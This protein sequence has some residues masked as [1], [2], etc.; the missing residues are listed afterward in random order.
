[1]ITVI[2][3]ERIRRAY[4]MDGKSMRQIEQEM[5]HSYHT[6]RKALDSAEQPPYTLQEPKP[7]PVLGAFKE[8][9]DELLAEEVKLPRKQRYTTH[10]LFKL[11]QA[12]GYQGSESGLRRYV[13]RKR[14]E[15][16]RPEVYIPLQ[17]RPGE[18]AQVDWG[19]ATVIMAGVKT[20]VQLFVMRLC[21]SRRTFVMAFPN[22]KQEA[23]FTAHIEAFHYFG[24]IARTLIYDNLTTAVRK[25][26][27]GRNRQEQTGFITFRSHYLFESRFA[28]P[29]AGHEKG[30]VEHGV[31]YVRQNY[32][33]PLPKAADYAE[34]NQ[35][36]GEQCLAD[37]TR[38]VDRQPTTIGQMW[39]QEQPALRPCPAS[40][41]APCISREVMLNR[42][43]QV[44]FETNRYSVPVDK[45]QKQL[46]LRAY[47]FRIEIL[48]GTEII[49]HHRRSYAR[50]QDVLNP[51]HYL[52]LLAQRPGAFDHA[53]PMQQWREQWPPLYDELLARL[54]ET[55]SEIVAVKE[56]IQIL[57]LHLEYEA[58]VVEQ[59]IEQAIAND[60]PHMNGVRFCLNRLLDITPATTPLLTLPQPHLAQVGQ[61][62]PPLR[63]Y[64]RLLSQVGAS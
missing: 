4:Y 33:V 11:I 40:D 27:K 9:I 6:I 1:M 30:G 56:F 19:E 45:A 44:I 32:L 5:G 54:K 28:N 43:G 51:L 60:M 50:C 14:Q 55:Q 2:D 29:G 61:Q 58:E 57:Q 7:A 10:K 15:M 17:F 35:W 59:A 53:Q 47:P 24:G 21:Y 16:K 48:N 8:A 49:A 25:I 34:L 23:F 41:F 26:L 39:Q 20:K 13:G 37:D 22:Q 31:K 46:T 62:P 36:L 42:Y 63:S 52:P 3:R 18:A 64:D 38:R 12:G